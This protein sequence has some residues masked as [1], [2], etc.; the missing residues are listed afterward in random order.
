MP[1]QHGKQTWIARRRGL[2]IALA[3]CGLL[4]SSGVVSA[5]AQRSEPILHAHNDYLHHRP[6]LDAL[7]HGFGSVEAD[8]FLVDGMLLVGHTRSELSA[9]RTL[10]SLY[11]EPLRKWVRTNRAKFDELQ[12][13]L[14][15]LVDIKSDA[16]AT[17]R[18]LRDQL[19]VYH[20][21]LT[22]VDRG[23][24]RLGEVTVIVSGNRAIAT[25]AADGQAAAAAAGN[26]ASAD[27]NPIRYVG[28]DG[29]LQDLESPLP[30]DLLPLISDN[31]GLNFSWRGEG[32]MPAAERQKLAKIVERAHA[33]QRR[34]RFWATPDNT[35]LWTALR[36]AGVDLINSDDLPGLSRFIGVA[37]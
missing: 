5:W 6:L 36:A 14:I 8:I 27:S 15:L 9:E 25:I 10:A 12:Q 4:L 3:A 11:L 35:S 13:P 7:D 32:E 31:W 24:L 20:E 21:M 23:R 26:A 18:A 33:G 29:R 37:R 2:P 19:A 16:E 34:I 28:V 30:T 22:L 1:G 17:Y